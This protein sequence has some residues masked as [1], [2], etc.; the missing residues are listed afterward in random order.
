MKR[1]QTLVA[2]ALVCI[3][4]GFTSLRAV[5]EGHKEAKATVRTVHGKVEYLQNGAWLAVHP[6]M[7]FAAGV[8]LRTGVDGTADISVNG[9]ASAVRLT[10]NTT[11]QIPTMSYVGTPREGDT[12]TMINLMNGAILGNV[13]KI[14]ANSRYEIMTPHGVAGIRGTDFRVEAV[15]TPDGVF[16]VRF[17]SVTGI[18]TVSAM[19][20]GV[21]VVHTLTTGTYWEI[22]ETPK[23]MK[24]QVLQGYQSDILNMVQAIETDI[25]NGNPP[26]NHGGGNNGNGNNGNGNGNQPGGVVNPFP[27]GGGTPGGDQSS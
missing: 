8:T 18:I 13:K 25:N 17:D 21:P 12:T 11:I 10:N 7:K 4:A 2:L 16:H 24:A 9:T 26:G 14:T 6:N 3:L 5:E 23:E 27:G 1:T 19:I 15:P 22:G 20:N